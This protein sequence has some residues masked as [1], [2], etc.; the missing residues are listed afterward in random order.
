MA[1]PPFLFVLPLFLFVRHV[2]VFCDLQGYALDTLS[3]FPK[4]SCLKFIRHSLTQAN[5]G[6]LLIQ[7]PLFL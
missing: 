4:N 3:Q 1:G 2:A 5:F 6:V 7:E